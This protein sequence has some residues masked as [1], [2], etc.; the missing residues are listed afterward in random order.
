MENPLTD[1]AAVTAETPGIGTILI[2]FSIHAF[3]IILP[4]SDISGVPASE[5]REIVFFDLK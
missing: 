1:I 3:T 5:I 4:G 2:L